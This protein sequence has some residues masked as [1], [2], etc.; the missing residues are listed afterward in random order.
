MTGHAVCEE[1]RLRCVLAMSDREIADAHRCELSSGDARRI[2]ARVGA[3][4]SDV[5]ELVSAPARLEEVRLDPNTARPA[6]L[7]N[8]PGL[9]AECLRQVVSSRPYFTAPELAVAAGVGRDVVDDLFALPLPTFTD[10]PTGRRVGLEPVPFAYVVPPRQ[11]FESA[12]AVRVLGEATVVDAPGARI[13]AVVGSDVVPGGPGD[14]KAHF[15]DAIVPVLRDSNGQQRYLV[16]GYLDIWCVPR[17]PLDVVHA[18]AAGSGVEVVESRPEHGYHRARVRGEAAPGGVLA[19][20]LDAVARLNASSHVLLAEPDEVGLDDFGPPARP[21]ESDFEDASTLSRTWNLESIELDEALAAS[22]G[23]AEVVVVVVDSGLQ[24]DHPDL[25]TALHPSWSALDLNF[26]SGVPASE[27]SPREEDVAHG[28]Q[29]ASVAVGRSAS[30]ARGV[31]RRASVLPVKIS[32]TP[33]GDSYALRALAIREAVSHVPPGARAVLNLSWSTSGE[34]LGIRDAIHHAASQGLAVVASAGNY[35][36]GAPQAP[37][38]PHYP[39]GYAWLPGSS[40]GDA[41]ARRRI[42]GVCSV[43]AV[44]SSGMKATYSYYGPTS[45]TVAAPGGE[46]G[47]HGSGIF[48]ASTPASYAYAHGTSFAAPHVAG[49]LALLWSRR[50]DLT[51]QAAID[52]VRTTATPLDARDPQHAGM[53][54]GGLVNA[55]AALCPSGDSGG[56]APPEGPAPQPVPDPAPVPALVDLNT[57][58]VAQ[59]DALPLIGPWTAERIVRHRQERGQFTTTQHLVQAGLLD[60]WT[61]RQVR[62]LLRV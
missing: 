49:L 40:P 56:S 55:R 48:V 22:A 61:Y 45:V 10:K 31:A 36:P 50:P 9:P 19:R 37:D 29:V 34:H 33:F 32:G 52:V 44:S 42:P 51:A 17:T 59:L 28:T 13:R 14:L 2:A 26:V 11:E 7:V 6:Q 41:A 16:P 47:G 23:S 27:A 24:V 21:L 39:S 4:A 58:T 15:R 53:L 8:V 30:G 46:S 12:E 62:H 20:T 43:A 38:T 5:L 54:G 35:R 60:A 25:A 57:A 3:R 1:D 18:L